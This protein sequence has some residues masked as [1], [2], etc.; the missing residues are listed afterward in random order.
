MTIEFSV[1]P[2]A[3]SKDNRKR[4]FH[5]NLCNKSLY[6]H[7]HRSVYADRLLPGVIKEGCK[8]GCKRVR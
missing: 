5:A 8:E 1:I 2:E 7:Q 4:E 3:K 6:G